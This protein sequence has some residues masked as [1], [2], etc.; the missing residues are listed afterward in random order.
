M[1]T[2][3]ALDRITA[4]QFL[5]TDTKQKHIV[6]QEDLQLF[7][8]LRQDNYSNG[9]LAFEEDR[10]LDLRSIVGESIDL[11]TGV[12]DANFSHVHERILDQKTISDLIK[13]STL[14]NETGD[15]SK[16][17][18]RRIEALMPYLDQ[19]L[20]CVCIR[21]P[22]VVYTIEIDPGAEKVIHWE[23]QSM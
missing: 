20:I 9:N 1:V 22:G 3:R 15:W 21:L 11:P 12:L 4:W 8:E 6:V 7:K 5:A 18:H 14:G 2:G 19:R 13:P 23:W 16:R 10:T 17:C